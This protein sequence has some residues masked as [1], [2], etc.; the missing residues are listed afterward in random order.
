MCGIF[1][2]VGTR[3]EA[4]QLVLAGLKKLEYRGYDSWGIASRQDEQLLV[5]KHVGKIGHAMTSLAGSQ[6]ALGHTRWATHGGVTH[7]NAHPH[8]DCHGRLAVIH[9]GII[10]NHSELKHGLLARGHVFTSQTDTEVVCH[11]LEDELAG[12]AAPDA[13]GEQFVR[14]SAA[15]PEGCEAL[16][17]ALMR[18]FR[19]LD[20]LSALGVLDQ[21]TQC[22]AAA[23][24]G[25][26]LV[27]GWG[28]DGNYL[29]SDSSAVLEHSRRLTFLED[30]QAALISG[31][32]ITVYDVASGVAEPQVRIWD[33]TWK[34]E[35]E[36]LDGFSDYMAKE[37]REQPAVLW[38]L[39]ADAGSEAQRLADEISHASTV[40]FVGCG[41]AA[42]AARCGDWLP[43]PDRRRS[44][45]PT[46]SRTPAPSTSS[47]AGR[48]R[49]P[50]AAA[51]TCSRA[52]RPA[53]P[54]ALSD[55]SS[56]I[57]P[58]FWTTAASSW[59]SARVVK[60]SI[61]SSR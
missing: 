21:H 9:N 28:T 36:G 59:G 6:A 60:P 39:A 22:I 55:P 37:I 57:W 45:W 29:A 25:S 61:C 1:G 51:S 41:S 47:A 46:R 16:V 50:R 26:P 4:P 11:M 54:T 8:L 52:L 12:D 5:E 7:A 24:N 40:H 56:G 42:H 33:I 48:R 20:G 2:Y 31:E 23:K 32:A 10:E 34:E 44:A 53:R 3:N 30:G 38:R 58:I 43:T 49:T 18:V 13:A 27:L 17:H 35:A 15:D 19:R 14:L